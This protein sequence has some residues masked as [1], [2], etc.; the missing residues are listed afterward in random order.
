MRFT[1]GPDDMLGLLL[2]W[3]KAGETRQTREQMETVYKKAVESPS[4]RAAAAH[5]GRPLVF[6]PK[7]KRYVSPRQAFWDDSSERF[8]SLV[9][10]GYTQDMRTIFVDCLCVPV[11]PELD[12]YVW[13]L[14]DLAGRPSESTARVAFSVFAH[15]GYLIEERALEDT[16]PRWHRLRKMVV[17]STMGFHWL[18]VRDHI[19]INNCKSFS[20][21]L[22]VRGSITYMYV[23]P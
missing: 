10:A 7:G 12:A 4:F 3:V 14:A 19:Y 2:R 9:D 16:D 15:F 18:S 22:P 11:H 20:S 23:T 17:F 21:P 1:M 6:D 13:M 8:V 5:H